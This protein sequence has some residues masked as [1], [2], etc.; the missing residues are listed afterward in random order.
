MVAGNWDLEMRA[1]IGYL[2]WLNW[3]KAGYQCEPP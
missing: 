3:F 1:R 2:K